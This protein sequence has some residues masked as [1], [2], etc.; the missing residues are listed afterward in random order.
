YS[1][2]NNPMQP[3]RKPD[4]TF[5]TGPDYRAA[6]RALGLSVRA[7]SRFLQV[8]ERTSR[9]RANGQGPVD[10]ATAALLR[11]MVG[12]KIKPEVVDA[13]IGEGAPLTQPKPRPGRRRL[14]RKE[15]NQHAVS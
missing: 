3:P 12:H 9:R 10:F 13:L 15:L 4:L 8:G 1:K 2:E 14:T 7:A 6:L 11:L 5:M